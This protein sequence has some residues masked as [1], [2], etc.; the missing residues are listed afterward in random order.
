MLPTPA[1]LATKAITGVTKL[2]NIPNR[3]TTPLQNCA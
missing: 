2:S 3:R 1:T